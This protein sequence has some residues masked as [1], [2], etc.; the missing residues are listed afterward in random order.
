MPRAKRKRKRSCDGGS[1]AAL[2]GVGAPEHWPQHAGV[3]RAAAMHSAAT[4]DTELLRTLSIRLFLDPDDH[5]VTAAVLAAKRGQ[6]EWLRAL[7]LV[8]SLPPSGLYGVQGLSVRNKR[9]WCVLI[10]V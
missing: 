1:S 9:G 5:G 8:P 3:L 6:A 2:P 7:A 4:G 10:S